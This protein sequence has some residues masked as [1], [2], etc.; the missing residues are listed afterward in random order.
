MNPGDP[1]T[2]DPYVYSS[3]NPVVY[4]DA[5]GLRQD[6]GGLKL[7]DEYYSA[8]ANKHVNPY[9]GIKRKPRDRPGVPSG[10]SGGTF[11]ASNIVLPP[12]ASF[13][14]VITPGGTACAST[15]TDCLNQYKNYDQWMMTPVTGAGMGDGYWHPTFNNPPDCGP[16]ECLGTADSLKV[17]ALLL[18]M[19]AAAELGGLVLDE[20]L[21]GVGAGVAEGSLGGAM[22]T[23]QTRG[24]LLDDTGSI[25]SWSTS[26]RIKQAGLP[27]SGSIRYI[28]PSTYRAGEPLQRG[29]AKGYMDRFGN[30]WAKGPSR[31]PGQPFEWD[32]QLSPQGRAS[33]GWLSRDGKHV[34][35]SLDGRVTH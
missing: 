2:L 6:V 35:V 31:T 27:N 16:V 14:V 22:R 29:P 4:T 34:N 17:M 32:V 26:A 20:L 19:V 7:N 23:P 15:A 8:P 3:D 24:M 5:S 25:G 33:I 1:R 9:T 18:V 13:D 28:P 10:S 30:E 21:V 12:G 11:A